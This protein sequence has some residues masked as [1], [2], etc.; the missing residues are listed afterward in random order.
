MTAVL[1]LGMHIGLELG[2]EDFAPDSIPLGSL[3]AGIELGVFADLAEFTTSF[4]ESMTDSELSC[5]FVGQQTYQLALGA[6]AGATLAVGDHSWGPEPTSTLPLYYTTIMSA[7]LG[8]KA[9]T[10]PPPAL[11]TSDASSPL[12]KRR[13]SFPATTTTTLTSKITYTAIQCPTGTPLC[14]VSQQTTSIATRTST[15]VTAV[16]S[17]SSASFP[18]T[19]VSSVLSSIDF[20]E[21][22]QSIFSSSG[23][24]VSYV[25]PP[26]PTSTAAAGGG[27]GGGGGGS[28]S[29][30]FGFG[31]QGLSEQQKII[32]G[33]CVGVGAPLLVGLL[34]GSVL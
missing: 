28:G 16:P 24:P 1:R 12:S 8:R 9:T 29:G 5:D 25:P 22:A 18:Q 26:P 13:G 23:R 27:A 33:V 34:A 31:S 10:T 6:D 2:T 30:L 14:P 21:K 7:C 32:I 17:G 3:T 20:G 11:I 19:T 4:N 15:L